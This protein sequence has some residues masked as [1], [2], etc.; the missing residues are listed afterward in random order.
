MSDDGLNVTMVYPGGEM[1][2]GVMHESQVP[3]VGDRWDHEHVVKSVDLIIGA[4]STETD[5]VVRLEMAS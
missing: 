1:A 2:D 3:R 4:A 5:V